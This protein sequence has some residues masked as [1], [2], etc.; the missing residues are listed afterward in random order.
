MGFSL[1]IWIVVQGLMIGFGAPL[2]WVYLGLG[3]TIFA[4]NLL[5]S[6]RRYYAVRN[7]PHEPS[8]NRQDVL[9]ATKPANPV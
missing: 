7:G 4:L 3:V 6:V 2:Q 9:K 5:P 1:M 8:K